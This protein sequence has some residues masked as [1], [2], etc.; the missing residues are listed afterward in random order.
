MVNAC[1]WNLVCGNEVTVS[2]HKNALIELR[3]ELIDE[4]GL[5]DECPNPR[6]IVY[7][8]ER[9]PMRDESRD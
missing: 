4:F 2:C 9:E 8:D 6:K 5:P 1:W 3:D 7:P